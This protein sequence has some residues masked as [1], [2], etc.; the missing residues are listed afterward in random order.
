M[1]ITIELPEEIGHKLQQ[2]WENL[3]QKLLESLALEAYRKGMITSAQIQTMLKFS[4]R[5]QTEQ[6]LK[7]NQ[8]YLDYTEEDLANDLETLNQLLSE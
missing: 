5:W 7:E 3:P 4:S 2:T 8:A 6:F 1:Q